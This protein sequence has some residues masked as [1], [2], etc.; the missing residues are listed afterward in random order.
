MSGKTEKGLE[1]VPSKIGIF[2]KLSVFIE[3]LTQMRGTFQ[4]Y[5]DSDWKVISSKFG[6][7]YTDSFE[8]FLLALMRTSVSKDCQFEVRDIIEPQEEEFLQ[9]NAVD[10]LKSELTEKCEKISLLEKENENAKSQLKSELEKTYLK[11]TKLENDL[12]RAQSEYQ[13]CRSSIETQLAK[14]KTTAN[15]D[16]LT[17]LLPVFDDLQTSMRKENRESTSFVT[18]MELVVG[19]LFNALSKKGFSIISVGDDFD[20]STCE[21]IAAVAGNADGKIAQVVQNGY[22]LNNIVLR[23]AKVIVYSKEN[24]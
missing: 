16:L 5:S 8:E 1:E 20:I 14:Q 19:N 23:H 24:E 15:A 10:K 7:D 11:M 18:N 21:A 4:K 22:V 3:A 13:S 6:V 2:D 17:S 9:K 12:V